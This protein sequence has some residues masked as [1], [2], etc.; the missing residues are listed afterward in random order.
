MYWQSAS[1]IAIV[2]SVAKAEPGWWSGG[3]VPYLRIRNNGHYKITITK[4]LGG[5][6]YASTIYVSGFANISDYYALAPGEEKYFAH[7]SAF[8]GL[9]TRCIMASAGAVSNGS[10]YVSNAASMCSN[11]S[12]Y[13]VLKIPNFGFEYIE[14]IEGQQ[15]TK[16]QTGREIIIKC[17]D[18]A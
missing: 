18:P 1:P 10:I 6:S 5:G 12:P 9:Q 11:V 4:V 16:R 7:S 14:E 2:E 17:I 15:I 3:A 13:G 8:S